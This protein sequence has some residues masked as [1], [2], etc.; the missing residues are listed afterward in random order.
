MAQ[1]VPWAIGSLPRTMLTCAPMLRAV[2]AVLALVCLLPQISN[3][4]RKVQFPSKDGLII[5]A[6]LYEADPTYPWVV[7]CHQA[8]SSRGE[9]LEIAKRLN[10][11]E[12]N[13]M[14]VDLRSGGEMNYISNETY[15]LARRSGLSTAYSESEK[16]MV[17]AVNNAF[18]IGKKKVILM[19]SS[20][21]ASLALKVARENSNV[22]AVVAM[23]PGEYFSGVFEV[24]EEVNGLDKPTFVYCTGE[25]RPYV[26]DLISGIGR[27]RMIVYSP[28]KGGVHG[29][30]ALFKESQGSVEL[31]IQLMN[32]LRNVKKEK[33]R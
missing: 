5:S 19:G 30:K 24:K 6:D 29:A 10:K 3:A 22:M 8:R 32:F 18:N 9:Y 11:L 15:N 2:V 16:D 23:S 28:D 13:C 7:L 21:S 1:F 12:F 17:T 27:R 20:Y 33:F 26:N 31:W 25:E 4:Q 14:A